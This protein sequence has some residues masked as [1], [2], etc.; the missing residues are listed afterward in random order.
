MPL[1]TYRCPDGHSTDHLCR[2]EQRPPSVACI[3]GLDATQAIALTAP[4]I[5]VGGTSG[6]K[7]RFS[8]NRAG[9]VEE[10]PGVWVKGSSA[11]N[12]SFTDYRCIG[13]G[14][15][16]VAVDEA[17]PSMC[18]AC[19]GTL[20]V[21]VNE[22]ARPKDWFPHG[23]YYDRA[24]GIHLHSRAHRAQE[25]EKRGLR[26]SDNFEIDDRFRAASAARSQQDRDITE[27]LDEWDD[28][29]DRQRLVD[30]GRTWDHSWAR[31]VLR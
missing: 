23:G 15:K 6:G 24:L 9:Y 31:E 30:E 22:G 25:L 2:Y 3:C 17:M 7:G 8:A 13:C 5:V 27:M 10:S 16:D 1:F 20:E 12:P 29:K 18:L 21:Y 28:D 4:G 11:L 14:R 26:E 19:G